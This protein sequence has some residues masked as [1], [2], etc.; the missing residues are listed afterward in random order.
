M[1]TGSNIPIPKSARW[2]EG[3]TVIYVNHVDNGIQ[4]EEQ[5]GRRYEADF[6]IVKGDVIDDAI[7]AFT[8]SQEDPVFDQ[9]VIDNI[10]V[11]GKPAIDV[12]REY[13]NKVSS[14]IFPPL[15][16][17]GA[18]KKGEVYSY[19]NGAVMVVQDHNRTIYPPEQTPALFSF[20]RDNATDL[21]WMEGEKVEVGWTRMY[22]GKKYEV[23]Q[24]HQTLSTWTP[25]VTPAL[26][27]EVVVV[28]DIPVWVQPTG[29]HD[30]YNIGDKVHFPTINDPVYESLIDNN[31]W[32]P[33]SYPAGWRKL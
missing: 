31:S 5:E 20:Y 8:R 10:E 1:K 6:T 29:A 3:E 33:T 19:N 16:S 23:L 11:E 30:A 4:P 28:V 12:I 7:Y 18:L 25:D 24:A 32:S 15:P 13:E 26:W 21:E 27:K 14:I 22:G 17:S 9:Q 2:K